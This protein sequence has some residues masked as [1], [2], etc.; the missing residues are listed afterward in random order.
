MTFFFHSIWSYSAEISSYGIVFHGVQLWK[1][2]SDSLCWLA[3]YYIKTRCSLQFF[4]SI[5]VQ[6]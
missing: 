3:D 4:L 6:K 1:K 5:V 2:K